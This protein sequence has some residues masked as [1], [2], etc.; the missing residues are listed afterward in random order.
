MQGLAEL[1][2]GNE[3]IASDAE[4]DLWEESRLKVC[5]TSFQRTL[6]FTFTK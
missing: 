2:S 4:L 1:S 5:H 6:K 3:K